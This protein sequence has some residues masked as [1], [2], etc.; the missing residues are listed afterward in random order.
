LRVELW[1][2]ISKI[3]NKTASSGDMAVGVEIKRA[4]KSGQFPKPYE[5]HSNNSS[6][7][8]VYTNLFY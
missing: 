3:I 7:F 8:V 5:Y 1:T 2:V 4:S 6:M